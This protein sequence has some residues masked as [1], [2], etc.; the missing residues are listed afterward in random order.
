[1]CAFPDV[2]KETDSQHSEIKYFYFF[3]LRKILPEVQIV[4]LYDGT[5]SCLA[6]Q[7]CHLK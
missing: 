5:L 2:K 6:G 1:M 4:I 3:A 7:I